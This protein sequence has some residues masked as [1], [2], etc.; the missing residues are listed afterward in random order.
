MEEAK[1]FF[2]DIDKEISGITVHKMRQ[3]LQLQAKE[4]RQITLEIMKLDYI[5]KN[6][7]DFLKT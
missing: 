3:T 7:D 2:D 5:E 1:E 6:I 4:S